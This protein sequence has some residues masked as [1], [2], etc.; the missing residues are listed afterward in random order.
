[1]TVAYDDLTAL[2]RS[3]LKPEWSYSHKHQMINR[4]GQRRL[5]DDSPDQRSGGSP[6]MNRC[7]QR[8]VADESP[9]QR[10]GVRSRGGRRGPNDN[11]V[12]DWQEDTYSVGK[13]SKNR[14]CM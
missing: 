12:A 8:H 3:S 13:A 9:D 14:I 5:R 11:A 1:M 2:P 6:T 7:A 10:S 4:F